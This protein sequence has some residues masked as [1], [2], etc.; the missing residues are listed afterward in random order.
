MRY[1]VLS[2][3]SSD[4]VFAAASRQAMRAFADY[5][6]VEYRE[7]ARDLREWADETDCDCETES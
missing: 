3:T 6:P 1:F 2:P 7:L 4:A 5:L